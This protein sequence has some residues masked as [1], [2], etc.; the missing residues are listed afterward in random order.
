M[1][2]PSLLHGIGRALERIDKTIWK[3]RP[4]LS[5]NSVGRSWDGREH[6]RS[7]GSWAYLFLPL[8][9]DGASLAGSCNKVI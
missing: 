7:G 3:D 2:S 9:S 6:W 4:D 1:D 5:H 8:S